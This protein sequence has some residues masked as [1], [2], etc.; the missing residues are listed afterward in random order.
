VKII[1]NKAGSFCAGRS[2]PLQDIIGG[3]ALTARSENADNQ[4][5]VKLITGSFN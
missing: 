3:I 2:T 5:E 4:L 1:T